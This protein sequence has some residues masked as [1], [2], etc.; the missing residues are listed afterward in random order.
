MV[1]RPTNCVKPRCKLTASPIVGR[2]APADGC[3]PPRPPFLAS[4]CAFS[5][6]RWP[7]RHKTDTETWL[8]FHSTSVKSSDTRVS[9][10]IDHSFLTKFAPPNKMASF[11]NFTFLRKL[12]SWPNLL[13]AEPPA[14]LARCSCASAKRMPGRV[15]GEVS[16]KSLSGLPASRDRDR[17]AAVRVF[18]FSPLA[19]SRVRRDAATSYPPRQ[20]IKVRG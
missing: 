17:R 18:V 9:Q 6:F 2:D 12:A 20:R 16:P 1:A 19:G 8:R 15:Q 14:R 10:P 13:S 3:I 11:C 7:I 4:L 5:A